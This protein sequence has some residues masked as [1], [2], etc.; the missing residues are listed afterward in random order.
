[1]MDSKKLLES[2]YHSLM[3]EYWRGVVSRLGESREDGKDPY[4]RDFRLL[5][6]KL[7]NM[8]KGLEGY[9]HGVTKF[10]KGVLIEIQFSPKPWKSRSK[11]RIAFSVNLVTGI[12]R[13][14]FQS[15]IGLPKGDFVDVSSEAIQDVDIP[16][17]MEGLRGFLERFPEY[18]K[19]V[20]KIAE[21]KMTEE[22]KQKKIVEMATQSIET[23]VP[24]IMSQSGYEWSLERVYKG[25]RSSG[26]P[27]GHIL[28]VKMKKHKMV[29]ITLSQNNFANKIPGI[30][31]VVKQIEQL[32]EQ[33]PYAVNIKSYGSGI[34]WIKDTEGLK[35]PK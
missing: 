33:A 10:L 20:E 19:E 27:D 34:H 32:L 22:I 16:A 12:G 30:L 5:V 9:V 4:C 23:I 25:W 14:F 17:T 18:E 21:A 8:A 35:F 7:I 3:D 31:N 24:Q 6:I 29:E 26:T 15:R 11:M 28:R 2:S 1:M 13:I